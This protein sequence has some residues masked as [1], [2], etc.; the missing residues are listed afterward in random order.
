M[1]LEII[2]LKT[3]AIEPPQPK[4][5]DPPIPQPPAQIVAPPPIFGGLPPPPPGI[6]GPPGVAGG[7][8][9]LNLLAGAQRQKPKSKPK[10]PMRAL[11]WAAITR[12]EEV[13]GSVFEAIEEEKVV[14]DIPALEE[15]FREKP[16]AEKKVEEKPKPT[17]PEKVSLLDPKRGKM[18]DILLA[19]LR[20]PGDQLALALFSID[21]RVLTP[22]NLELLLPVIPTE[23]EV[24]LCRGF[25][26]DPIVLSSPE[27]FILALATIKGF[28]Q[29]IR[30]LHFSTVSQA[31]IA[32]L[33]M[34][35][36]G[37]EKAWEGLLGDEKVPMLF[38]HVL[39]YGNYLNGTSARGG[40]F[41]FAFDGLEKVADC[42][43]TSNP[44]RNLLVFVLE[45]LEKSSGRP[46]VSEDFSYVVYEFAAKV[47]IKQLELDLADIKK[48]AES[49]GLAIGTDT[50]DSADRI[51]A[52]LQER[53]EAIKGEIVAIEQKIKGVQTLYTRTVK[54]LC[55]DSKEGS[56]GTAR[57]LVL[58]WQGCH[59]WRKE[60]ERRRR[61]AERRRLAEEKRIKALSIGEQPRNPAKRAV[62]NVMGR[63]NA[64]LG[65]INE[66]ASPEEMMQRL[67][68]KRAI[69]STVF[70]VF[71]ALSSEKSRES[72]R[73]SRRR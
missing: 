44:K 40:A 8:P 15:D 9:A 52:S 66:K 23:E 71:L 70:D 57:K 48:G 25:K 4:K 2:K 72:A 24:K 53:W 7:P 16:A 51:K 30:G 67:Q 73:R 43:S 47:P 29:R 3:Q 34:K 65:A 42:R 14:L 26:G 21:E 12:F 22:E 20:L 5:Q 31:L 45:A 62:E 13:K 36:E 64:H 19:K 39:A 1:A 63:D 61:E 49:M 55:E 37:L 33:R 38:R 60:V 54:Y 56:E 46:L 11:M 50:G 41:G 10:V 58:M 32:D 28:G 18:F 17:K 59:G 69:K 6:I 35:A 68:E 27:K